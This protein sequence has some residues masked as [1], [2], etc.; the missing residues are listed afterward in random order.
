ML[1][2]QIT[3]AAVQLTVNNDTVK[4][5][6]L[7]ISLNQAAASRQQKNQKLGTGGYEV[8]GIILLRVLKGALRFDRGKDMSVHISTCTSYD[9]NTLTTGISTSR[10]KNV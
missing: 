8:P 9:F 5:V 7:A 3:V 2:I 6:K 10:R 4:H 1:T